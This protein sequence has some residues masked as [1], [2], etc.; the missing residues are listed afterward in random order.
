M[1]RSGYLGF[2]G[3]DSYRMFVTPAFFRTKPYL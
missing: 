2:V 3:Q 1:F